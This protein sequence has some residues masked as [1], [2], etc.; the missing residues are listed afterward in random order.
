MVQ[1]VYENPLISRYASRRMAA[2]WSAQKKHSTW[3]RLWVA[4]AESQRELGLDISQE[5]IDEMR[6]AVDD[7]DFEK[8][9]EYERRLRHDV[10]AHVH[11]FADRCPKARGIIHLGATSCFVTD[12]TELIQL[13][14]SLELVRSRL[15]SVIDALARFA[16][17]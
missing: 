13:R 14:A 1:D 3:R 11:T 7:I 4:L 16:E 5:Q 2:I 12:N 8:A 17:R 15:V 6:A 10:M 9:A